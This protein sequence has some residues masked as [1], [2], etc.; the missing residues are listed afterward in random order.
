MTEEEKAIE[1][2]KD[3][4]CR[5]NRGDL[6]NDI[7]AIYDVENKGYLTRDQTKKFIDEWLMEN[8]RDKEEVGK[9]KFEDLS[10]DEN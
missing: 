6:T 1:V 5:Q 7:F 8:S 4:L 10:W 3:P 2:A 9:I